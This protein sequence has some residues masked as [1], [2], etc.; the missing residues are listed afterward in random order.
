MAGE[1]LE[2]GEAIA[3]QLSLALDPYPR[4]PGATLELDDDAEAAPEATRPNPFAKLAGLKK[5]Q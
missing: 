3:E 1:H 2:L 5:P 4:V